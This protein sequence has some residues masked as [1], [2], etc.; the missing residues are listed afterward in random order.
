MALQP[1]LAAHFH[2]RRCAR[3]RDVQAAVSQVMAPI[4]PS[5]LWSV[6]AI[7]LLNFLILFS[8]LA[9]D[10][11]TSHVNGWSFLSCLL[12]QRVG[13]GGDPPQL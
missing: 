8:S 13:A 1:P 5:P 2:G 7:V 9:T 3:K 4:V 11:V 12:A 6:F 10:V